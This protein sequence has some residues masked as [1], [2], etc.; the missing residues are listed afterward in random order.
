LKLNS[1]LKHIS[2]YFFSLISNTV[3][4]GQKV[5][6]NVPEKLRTL[7]ENFKEAYT[8]DAYDYVEHISFWDRFKAWFIDFLVRWFDFNKANTVDVF[9]R[10]KLIFYFLV[11][12]V[13]LYF[14]VKLILNKEV[15]WLFGKQTEAKKD[16]DLDEI[17]FIAEDDFK[18]LII[19]AETI[20][21]YRSAIKYYYL[22][23][24]KK[25]DKADQIKYDPQK[26]SHDYLLYL[27]GAKHYNTF[28]K[29]AYYYTYI[30]YGEFEI[31]EK[32]YKTAS[33]VFVELLK[34]FGNE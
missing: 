15:R 5:V 19:D 29:A 9:Q 25:M 24:L 32:E 28:S 4:C 26:T 2:L 7:S 6:A 10:L 13:V 11:I 3:I 34:Q 12:A 31:N 1:N 21:D 18:K 14:I 30:W 22:F 16:I 33:S 23:L 20:Q 27:E 17:K 8:S